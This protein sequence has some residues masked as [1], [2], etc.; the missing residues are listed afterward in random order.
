MRTC[1]LRVLQ[2]EGAER[3]GSVATGEDT[4]KSGLR[5]GQGAG[6]NGCVDRGRGLDF[7]YKRIVKP[8]SLGTLLG[9]VET[10]H[11]AEATV[12]TKTCVH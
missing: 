6:Q 1:E 4:D 7:Y 5:G 3:K 9:G 2:T 11:P 12:G 10:S 8:W